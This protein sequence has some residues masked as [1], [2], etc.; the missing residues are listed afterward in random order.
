MSKIISLV[1]SVEEIQ[2]ILKKFNKKTTIVPLDLGAQLYCIDN[3]I[4]FYD[5]LNLVKNS[6]H[7][8]TIKKSRDF[9]NEIDYNDI[10]YESHQ[11]EIKA[12]LRFRLHAIAFILEIINQLKLQ[13]KINEIVLSGWDKYYD[14]YSPKNYFISQIILNLINDIK[15]TT[16]KEFSHEN[17]SDKF[18]YDYDILYTNL[19]LNKEYIYLSN[20]GYNFFR[21]I[22]ILFKK[23]RKILTISFNK[24][25]FFKKIIYMMMGIKFIE[26]KKNE[27]K[28]KNITELLKIDLKYKYK[29]KDLSKLL[30]IR[31]DQEKNN[32]INMIN[33]SRLIDEL[34]KKLK[35]KF[36][37]T[38]VSRGI[39]GYFIDAA[40]N[41]K[42]PSMCIPHG[43]LS[44]NFDEYD[45]IYKKT[46][47]EA[48]TSKNATF[49]VS[50][51][52]ISKKFYEQN[53]KEYNNVI[54]TGNLIFSENK[55]RL[56]QSKK[57]L[58]AVTVKSLQSIQLVGVEMYYEFINNLYFLSNFS[59]KY[60]YKILVK[61]Y[62]G[63]YSK[64]NIL[65]K[66][67]PHLEFSKEKISPKIFNDCL[68]TISFSST[69]IEDSLNSL[70]PVILLD[71][72]KRYQH[73]EA[74]TN[75]NKKNSA[76]YY[77]NDEAGLIKCIKTIKASKK[78]N[79]S[80][81]VSLNN[82][83]ININKLVNKY[84]LN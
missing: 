36:V 39:F 40:K 13:K 77:I 31:I 34:F 3:N 78:I 16:L 26:I 49:N 9:L 72:W 27:R 62:P 6:F 21:I 82:Y 17:H 46:I 58:F 67:F 22:F 54:N 50:Q 68:L 42:I 43:T 69:V 35:I 60:N 4:D 59:K 45:I 28:I 63:I 5:P 84:I 48:V 10:K 32:V 30:N 2:F 65:K 61:L 56:N 76:V 70:R 44:K 81:Y 19:N 51:S 12:F 52:H 25:S 20:L 75:P 79:F 57:I 8:E 18:I 15:I 47:S 11:K 80:D 24:I 53:I 71:R 74:E 55:K 38:N 14:T 66:I 73:C 41:F 29:D 7:Y 33:K 37:I 1:Q 83:N 64:F 23:K